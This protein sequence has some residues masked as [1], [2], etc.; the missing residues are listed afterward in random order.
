MGCQ[1]HGAGAMSNT[2]SWVCCHIVKEVV[3]CFC[4]VFSGIGLLRADGTECCKQFVVNC[5]GIMEE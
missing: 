3:D 1:N 2:I 5:S 4:G